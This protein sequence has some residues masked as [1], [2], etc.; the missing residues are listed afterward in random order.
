MK[1][2]V[3]AVLLAASMAAGLV[4]RCGNGAAEEGAGSQETS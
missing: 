3:F 1:R 4:A 2:K